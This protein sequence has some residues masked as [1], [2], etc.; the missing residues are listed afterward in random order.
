MG[1]VRQRRSSVVVA[2]VLALLHPGI[3]I[4]RQLG[5]V[6]P[7]AARPA[8]MDG[9]RLTPCRG[10]RPPR[11]YAHVVWI[12]FENHS[13]N[14]VIGSSE[15]PYLTALSRTCGLATRYSAITHPS[16]PNYIAATSGGTQGI[17]GDGPPRENETGA[18]SVFQLA[19]SWKAYQ[20]AMPGP[21]RLRD[22]G[23]YAVRHD[24]SAYYL[25]LRG[26]L[27][28]RDV[29][30]GTR[31]S[32]ALASDL[33]HSRLP[34][35][36]FITPDLCNDMHDCSVATGDAWLRRWLPVILSSRTYRAGR[37]AVFVT[38]DEGEGGGGNRVA[39]IAVAPSVRRGSRT[40]A[41]LD[42]YALLRTTE[43]MLGLHPLLGRAA[44]ARSMRRL[45]HL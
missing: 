21:C 36:S 37:T 19:R 41:A 26:V 44:H 4:A 39:T 25:R 13:A 11:R 16:L 30:L 45:L 9:R 31:T 35:F 33:R 20:E 5:T 8:A 3:A 6:G 10:T 14:Q 7:T 34:R 1:A 24:P 23:R 12:W 15:A 17:H 40:A 28:R 22:A 27:C 29:P 2:L 18:V 32:G 43:S 38:W 42:H